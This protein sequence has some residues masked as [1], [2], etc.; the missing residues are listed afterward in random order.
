MPS[1]GLCVAWLVVVNFF[2]AFPWGAIGA[3]AAEIVPARMRAQGSALYFL[4]LSLVS[5]TLGPTLVAV[6][7]DYVFH[8]DSA[9][10]YSLAI[11]NVLGM[12]AAIAVLLYGMPA[13]RRTIA[14]RGE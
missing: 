7:T 12:T 6:I 1:A 3:S 10:G 13:Y 14:T 4:V 5:S 9:V 8:A 11:A 2:A